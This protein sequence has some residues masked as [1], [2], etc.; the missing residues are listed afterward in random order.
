M[1]TRQNVSE[2]GF[3]SRAYQLEMFDHS[4]KANTIVVMGTGTGKTHIA[5]LRIAFE[6]K[7][8]PDRLVWFTSPKAGLVDQQYQYLMSELPECHIRSF[9]GHDN[10]DSWKSGAIWR[11][12]LSQV[13]VVVTTP[14]ILCDALHHAYVKLQNIS[15]LIFDEAHHCHA[16]SPSARIMNVFY[17]PL[18]RSNGINGVPHI[19]GLTASAQI[20]ESSASVLQLEKNLNATCR[21]P[22]IT[23]AQYTSYL[24]K[25]V[26][27][28]RS[29]THMSQ[30]H[31]ALFQLL[32]RIVEN[33]T[34][35]HDPY[36][37][38]LQ[39]ASQHDDDRA[40]RAK[41]KLRKYDRGASTPAIAEIT[42]LLGNARDLHES[43]GAWAS[44]IYITNCVRKWQNSAGQVN[45]YHESLSPRS[46][47]FINTLLRC[48]RLAGSTPGPPRAAQLS[49]KSLALI[50]FLLSVYH[51]DIQIII[52]VERRATAW[53]LCQLLQADS[54]L[55]CYGIFSYVGLAL[56][57]VTALHEACVTSKQGTDFMDFRKGLRNLCIATSVAEEG[58]D[59][60]AVNV[61]IRYDDPKQF[62]SYVQSRGRARRKNSKIVCFQDTNGPP[63]KYAFW[64]DF[65]KQMDRLYHGEEKQFLQRMEHE[66]IVEDSDEYYQVESTGARLD[67]DISVPHLAH[68]CASTSIP[69]DP[70]YILDGEPGQG[71]A[72]KV[73]LPSTVPPAIRQASACR[74]WKSERMA[75]R[76]AAFHAMK[77]LHAAGLIN[78]HLVPFEVEDTSTPLHHTKQLRT[79]PPEQN[80]WNDAGIIDV[81][82]YAYR[83]E[84][85]HGS[86][87]YLTL[88]LILS[89]SLQQTLRF[90]LSESPI[91][92]LEVSIV[93]IGL[94]NAYDFVHASEVTRHLFEAA[95]QV[96]SASGSLADFGTLT[97]FIVPEF[98]DVQLSTGSMPLHDFLRHHEWLHGL[99][100]LL[101]WRTTRPRPYLWYPPH[102][103]SKNTDGMLV[104]W[105]KM[106]RKLQIF[107]QSPGS[108]T[109][110]AAIPQEKELLL[111][112]CE[113]RG[114]SSVYGPIVLLLPT[115]LHYM[116]AAIRAQFANSTILRPIG[117]STMEELVPALIA[118]SASG[119]YNYERLEFLGDACLK[120]LT[121]VQM[122][123][124]HPLAPEGVLTRKTHEIIGNTRLE[125]AT[126]ELGVIPFITTQVAR[127]KHWKLPSVRADS[128][129]Q[130]PRTILSKCLADVSE[131]IL[132][133][134]FLDGEKSEQAIAQC[135]RTLKLLIPEVSWQKPETHIAQLQMRTTQITEPS[136]LQ[137]SV[138]QIFGR[139]FHN[140]AL[141]A[142][143]LTHSTD[144]IL[145]PA[146]DRL[147]FLGDAILDQII[148]VKLFRYHDLDAGRLTV[149]RHALVSHAYLAYIVLGIH[150]DRVSYDVAVDHQG[151]TS[152]VTSTNRVE[153]TD[154][155]KFRDNSMRESVLAAKARYDENKYEIM[156]E[157]EA[158]RFPW[159]LLARLNTPKVCSDIIES[160]LA[161]LYL[162]SGGC[163]PRC[164]GFL[165]QLGIMD[166]LQQMANNVSF[167]VRTPA[168]MLRDLCE[169]CK[170]KVAIK[171]RCEEDGGIPVYV[172]QVLLGGI[173]GDISIVRMASCQEE[174]RSLA[175]E[176]AREFLLLLQQ[177]EQAK[178]M[179][180]TEEHEHLEMDIDTDIAM[181]GSFDCHSPCVPP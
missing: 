63:G 42:K 64:D 163:L 156:S 11:D 116:S 110:E 119:T 31:S 81:P 39:S 13:N 61:V 122:F 72:A 90:P 166:L 107:T 88:V 53:A 169:R 97:C 117:F 36:Y 69:F 34:N 45:Q 59:V 173:T 38:D 103:L 23:I 118:K 30:T 152:S 9:T 161:A 20:S 176:A 5:S 25:A 147:E 49:A 8:S 140:S 43:L 143:A 4:C 68:F 115:I 164:E 104:L 112:K 52:F 29:Y 18:K 113:A 162:T 21:S 33:T 87:K 136:I 96:G 15:L 95:F 86:C 139:D 135:V 129:T 12:M 101:I 48:L 51:K 76:D 123:F 106:I 174:A 66:E 124:D 1:A 109:E 94:V 159:T 172:G 128:E 84:V 99:Q 37:I 55:A 32:E 125:R 146:L 57:T 120:Y 179:V 40:L 155:V 105:A 82:A 170:I 89:T 70:I 145:Q 114:I 24:Q 58:I 54:R 22:T 121:S 27:I 144:D 171:A 165:D 149:C 6:L 102:E 47:Q 137:R 83:I 175:A 181:S 132:G 16:N 134:A 77:A 154:L 111:E 133:A 85:R 35:Q 141:L 157:F 3:Q 79:I 62:T 46:Q 98:D 71:V 73:R 44:D 10:V 41:Q 28:R 180:T 178:G 167:E 177:P 160:L 75:K 60:Q 67:L 65:E 148:K 138:R 19:L 100:P 126:T 130:K 150:Y 92:H 142:E 151:D 153:L 14:Q 7:R 78:D 17:H 91:R 131:S 80:V 50:D 168:T 158:G 56:G 127:Q 93:P 26:L 74:V 2:T 108:A